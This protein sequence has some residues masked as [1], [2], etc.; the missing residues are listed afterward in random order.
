MGDCWLICV[1]TD[2]SN[3]EIK[4]CFIYPWKKELDWLL[5][6]SE[7]WW[8]VEPFHARR[9]FGDWSIA[10][11]KRSRHCNEKMMSEQVFVRSKN[12]GFEMSPQGCFKS[13]LKT[14]N[15]KYINPSNEKWIKHFAWLNQSIQHDEKENSPSSPRFRR[16][17]YMSLPMGCLKNM[18]IL[19]GIR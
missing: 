13:T 5:E 15:D 6:Q 11:I 4:M 12:R 19:W 9:Y 16:S 7:C 3:C 10:L 14:M 2:F 1:T 17:H 8:T 18:R